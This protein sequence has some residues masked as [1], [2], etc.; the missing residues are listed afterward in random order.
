VSKVTIERT[1]SESVRA[2]LRVIIKRI[3]RWHGYPPDL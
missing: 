2:Q 1:I 3:L